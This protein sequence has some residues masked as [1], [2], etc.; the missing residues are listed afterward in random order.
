MNIYPAFIIVHEGRQ[1][2]CPAN[3]D[4][5]LKDLYGDY[6]K[7]PPEEKRVVH[8]VYINPCLNE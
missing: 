7:L 6:M 8:A 2:L 4:A 5:Y 1:F 3:P